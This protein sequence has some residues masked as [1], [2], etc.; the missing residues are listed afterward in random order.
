M[1][2][3]L[4]PLLQALMNGG[5]MDQ[6]L[7]GLAADDPLVGRMVAMMRDRRQAAAARSEQTST[8]EDSLSDARTQALIMASELDTLRDR[9]RRL[10][11]ALG[12]CECFGEVP[13]CPV[14]GGAGRTGAYQIDAA[15]FR[16]IVA[17]AL[18]QVRGVGAQPPGNE[19]KQ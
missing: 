1:P 5:N 7:D 17:P 8:A 2:R 15:L 16:T 9:N 19:E 12:A 6:I 11:H 18:A 10:A 13:R 3:D 14:C 4:A